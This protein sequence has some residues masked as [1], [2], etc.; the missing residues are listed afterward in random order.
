MLAGLK[1]RQPPEATVPEGFDIGDCFH[2]FAFDA[3]FG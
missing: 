1:A 2:L 3:G